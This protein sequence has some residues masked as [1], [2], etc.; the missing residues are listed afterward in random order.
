[1]KLGATAADSV[2]FNT[3]NMSNICKLAVFAN[4]KTPTNVIGWLNRIL[5][6][7][8]QCVMRYRAHY[9]STLNHPKEIS[10]IF[11]I[12]S[13]EKL[14]HVDAIA[15]KIAE[16]GGTP[17]FSDG[18]LYTRNH[19]DFSVNGSLSKMIE[20]N[21]YAERIAVSA[22]RDIINYLSHRDPVTAAML[23]KIL[24]VDE[25]RVTELVD[26][27]ADSRPHLTPAV[28]CVF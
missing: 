1:M 3:F 4:S 17:D 2:Q 16:L 18:N 19:K 10:K 15:L 12:H 26:W 14:T 13:N 8:T 24:R 6:E 9:F 7:E 21:L 20:E 23:E 11:L 5:S 22:Y 27:L 25:R 28:S